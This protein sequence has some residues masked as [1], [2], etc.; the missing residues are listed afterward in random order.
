[1]YVSKH[2]LEIYLD[3]NLWPDGIKLHRFMHFSKSTSAVEES[4]LIS[5]PNAI[6][7]WSNSSI[8]TTIM[9]GDF[10]EDP[11][12]D[13]GVEMLNSCTH[14]QGICADIIKIDLSSNAFTYVSES[15]GARSWLDLCTVTKSARPTT[16]DTRVLVGYPSHHYPLFI[17]C[18]LI[19]KFL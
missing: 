15:N 9:L 8:D 19:D 17:E 6:M 14:R 1:M 13:F 5:E 2:K 3:N 12:K 16:I 4:Q 10:N 7:E 11:S 18:N